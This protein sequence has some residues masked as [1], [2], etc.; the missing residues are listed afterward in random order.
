MIALGIVFIVLG[1][2]ILIG[3]QIIL[4]RLIQQ[5]R[6]SWENQNEMY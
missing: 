1:A 3:A 4:R 2:A 5:Y 6:K